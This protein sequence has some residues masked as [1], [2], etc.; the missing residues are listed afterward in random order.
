M[1]RTVASRSAGRDMRTHAHSTLSSSAHTSACWHTCTRVHTGQRHHTTT[2]WPRLFSQGANVLVTNHGTIKLADFG[3]SKR[4]TNQGLTQMSGTKGTPLWM[5]P[6]VIKETQ[7][8]Q[9]WKKVGNRGSESLALR[10][11][12]RT[13]D[14]WSTVVQALH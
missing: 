7:G 9:G 6:E 13:S 3:A 2:D 4:L 14:T 11:A 5:A 10:P 8:H 12:G 1:M